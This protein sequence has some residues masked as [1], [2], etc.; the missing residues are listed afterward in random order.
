MKLLLVALL[1]A[2]VGGQSVIRDKVKGA[3]II[4]VV[5]AIFHGNCCMLLHAKLKYKLLRKEKRGAAERT[6]KESV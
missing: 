6:Y 2:S 5:V 1:I 4:L 3:H